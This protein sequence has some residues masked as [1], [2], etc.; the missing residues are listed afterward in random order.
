VLLADQDRALGSRARSPRARGACTRT[1]RRDAGAAAGPYQ[2]QAA[3]A[4]SRA[5]RDRRGDGWPRIA[6]LYTLLAQ[7]AP[8]PIVELNRAVAVAMAFGPDA[9]LEL[10]DALVA[11]GA[12]AAYHLLPAVRGDLLAKLGRGD[13]ARAEFQRAAELT[14]N[15]RE[16]DVL[17]ARARDSAVSASRGS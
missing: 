14:R 10:V 7:R 6:A 9:G 12:L 2:L 1:A 8:S 4:A 3:I 15:E 5:R 17:L 13:E 16:R 11:D